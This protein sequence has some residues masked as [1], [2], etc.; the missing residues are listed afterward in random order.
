MSYNNAI[1]IN[2]SSSITNHSNPQSNV[3]EKGK[4]FSHFNF[5]DDESF[6]EEEFN[7]LNEY[8]SKIEC[9]ENCKIKKL[10][11]FYLT[12]GCYVEYECEKHGIKNSKF[13][14]FYNIKKNLF[15]ENY[16]LNINDEELKINFEEFK[17]IKENSL[18]ILK[19]LEEYKNILNEIF[20]KKISHY[21]SIYEMYNEKCNNYISLVKNQIKLCEY[22]FYYFQNSKN[23]KKFKKEEFDNLNLFNFKYIKFDLP[24]ISLNMINFN[25]N[26]VFDRFQTFCFKESNSILK[27]NLIIKNEIIYQPNEYEKKFYD[28]FINVNYNK[29]NNVSFLKINKV[30]K[31]LI[32]FKIGN[33]GYLNFVK[34][35][36]FFKSELKENK[37]G[38][39]EFFNA[40]K[41]I[42]GKWMKN[43]NNL[44][45]DA[46]DIFYC[47]KYFIG[48][49]KKLNF[50]NQIIYYFYGNRI[51]CELKEINDFKF[52]EYG[53]IEK[54][55]IFDD[56]F[57][58]EALNF[59][60]KK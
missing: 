22:Q 12:Y 17:K 55:E 39:V 2:D 44:N 16:D 9:N 37:N 38:F 50:N 57:K 8:L 53:Y 11:I 47:S 58:N 10:K 4:S 18:E 60:N 35:H 41:K 27:E 59:M 34:Q 1:L 14:D 46:Y 42:I 23:N 26:H 51:E 52:N 7:F 5:E 56:N 43:Y 36:I 3:S 48:K 21:Q 29:N 28:N 45:N 6:Y 49:W 33:F 19:K 20:K 15:D 24:Q 54:T 30:F 25:K 32:F 40:K 13:N 31:F